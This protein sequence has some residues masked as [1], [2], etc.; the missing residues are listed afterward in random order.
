MEAPRLKLYKKIGDIYVYI[1]DGEMI[2]AHL[3]IDF[4]DYGHYYSIKGP[5]KGEFWMDKDSHP[6][7]YPLFLDAMIR[8]YTLMEKG[9]SYDEARKEADTVVQR[10]RAKR[11]GLTPKDLKDISEK[12]IIKR[13]WT[14]NDVDVFQVRGKIVRAVDNSYSEGGHSRVYSYV[15]KPEG[16]AGAIWLDDALQNRKTIDKLILFHEY[17]EF[18]LMGFKMPY[19][20]AHF[21]ASAIELN[22]RNFLHNLDFSLEYT[23]RFHDDENTL[24]KLLSVLTIKKL[25]RDMRSVKDIFNI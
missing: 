23:I 19:E 6:E 13:L 22:C 12:A 20:E 25:N 15:K 3:D 11:F 21:C 5:P 10:E 17:F 4:T 7:E 2:R 1:V 18:C 14:F 16:K 24:M 9:A 8:E